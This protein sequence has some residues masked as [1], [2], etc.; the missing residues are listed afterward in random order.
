M[1]EWTIHPSRLEIC[2]VEVWLW[3]D[4]PTWR[5]PVFVSRWKPWRPFD[6]GVY[7]I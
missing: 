2:Y 1:W 5:W 7:G 3:S 4:P 6:W